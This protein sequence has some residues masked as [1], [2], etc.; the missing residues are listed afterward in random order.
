MSEEKSEAQLRNE[1]EVKRILE[2]RGYSSAS[3]KKA[4]EKALKNKGFSFKQ[5]LIGFVAMAVLIAG[6]GWAYFQFFAHKDNS[7]PEETA[8]TKHY[9]DDEDDADFV[10]FD[11]CLNAVDKS[12]VS[13][14]DPEFW[15]K[16]ISRYESMISCYDQYP[17][18]G[19]D[20]DKNKLQET[21]SQ[22]KG[23][24][25]QAINNEAEYQ[26][27]MAEIDAE[28]EQN[29][30]RI[31]AESEAW[32]AEFAQRV[33]EREAE[34]NAMHAQWEAERQA[35]EEKEAECN[36]FESEYPD[37]ETYK[38]KNGNLDELWSNY[39][40]AESAYLSALN[41]YGHSDPNH[42]DEWR[43][44]V[45]KGVETKKEAYNAAHNAW[46][47]TDSNLSSQYFAEHQQI[48]Y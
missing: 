7:E 45:W 24:R 46:S 22:Y 26:A 5:F 43:E 32:D 25:E 33:Q 11:N 20:Y 21:L 23:F 27:R 17:G 40:E 10:G 36:A 14:D 47:S 4:T 3:S 30:A 13:L 39:K 29:L 16:Y 19:S 41:A 38:S 31:Q 9:Y 48:C 15:D 37:V 8:S 18:I 42:S 6:G 34:S 12:E 2:E 35:R 1:A 44:A 28:L